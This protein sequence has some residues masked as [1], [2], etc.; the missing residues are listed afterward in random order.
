VDLLH[1]IY[2]ISVGICEKIDA[3]CFILGSMLPILFLFERGAMHIST[4]FAHITNLFDV[5]Y[6]TYQGTTKPRGQSNTD[7]IWLI[8][9]QM[10]F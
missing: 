7:R 1:S 4:A 5:L 3:G 9:T 10:R 6:H 2:S 8:I